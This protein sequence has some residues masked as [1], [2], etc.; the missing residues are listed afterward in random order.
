[1]AEQAAD[2][3][4]EIRISAHNGVNHRQVIDETGK[5]LFLGSDWVPGNLL[6]LLWRRGQEEDELHDLGEICLA[7][8][9]V[10]G[11]LEEDV[12]VALAL[13]GG[14]L[15]LLFGRERRL[16][17]RSGLAAITRLVGGLLVEC[18][19]FGVRTHSHSHW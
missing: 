14:L 16:G 13:L 11:D 2:S 10:L 1:M 3:L 19:L 12:E 5:L 18:D 17:S 15:L 9:H 6:V 8:S 7:L 4:L